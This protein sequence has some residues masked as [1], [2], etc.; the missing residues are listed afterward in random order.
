MANPAE[1]AAQVRFALSQLPAQNAHH[2][3]EQ[4]CRHLTE[5]F[6]CSNVLPAT[7]PVSAGGDQGRDFETFR[8]YLRDELGPTGAF[9][10]LVSEGTI[11]FVCTI[12]AENVTGKLRRD[13]ET[14]CSSG[15]PVHEIR[16]FALA[17]V[18]VGARHAL[19]TETRETHNVRL[20]LHD[21]ESIADLLARAQGFWIAEHFLSL[22]AEIRPVASPDDGDL[23]DDYVERRRRWRE[24]RTLYPT[25][26]TFLD[27]KAGLRESMYREAARNDLPFWLGLTRELLANSGL[28]AQI[29]QRARYELVVATLRGTG[30]LRPV[31]EVVRVYLN[32]SLQESEPAHLDDAST[33]LIYAKAATRQRITTIR[34]AELEYWSVELTRHIEERIPEETPHRRASLL[35]SLGFL[36]LHPTLSDSQL[37]DAA[38]YD[39][40][41]ADI[42]T[43]APPWASLDSTLPQDFVCRDAPRTLSAWTELVENLDETPLFPLRTLAAL[44]QLLL[45]LWSTQPEWRR[46]LDLVDDE[47]GAREGRNAVAERARARATALMNDGRNIEALEELHRARV[48]WWSGDTVR[49]SILASLVIARLYQ[50]LRLNTAAKAHALAAATIA[51]SGDEDLTDLAPDGLL[52][53]ALSEFLSGAWYGAAELYGLG[54]L[55]QHQLGRSGIDLPEDELTDSAVVHLAHISLCARQVDSALQSA[56]QAILDRSGL[57]DLIDEVIDHV[58]DSDEWTWSSFGE[59][60]LTDPPFADL[61]HTRCIRFAALGT[62]WTLLAANDNDS[63]RVAERFAAGVQTVLAALAREDLCLIPTE[64]TVRIEEPQETDAGSLEPIQALPSNEGREWTVRLAPTGSLSGTSRQSINTELMAVLTTILREASLLPAD[65]FLAVMQ[66]AF[67]RGLG[68]K[69]SAA[70]QLEEFVATFSTDQGNAFPRRSVEVPW[71][72]LDGTFTTPEELRWQDGPG[73]TYSSDKA[74]QLLQTRYENLAQGLRITTAVLSC[75]EEFRPT[76]QALRANGWLD[77]HILTAIANIT[78]NYRFPLSSTPPS[79]EY[80]NE[81]V[82]SASSPESATAPPVPVSLLTPE[83]MQTARQT[84]MMS[85]LKHWG[86]ECHQLTPD[87]S[88][89]E[90]LLVTRYGYWNEDVPH[91]DSFPEAGDTSDLQILTS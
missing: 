46:L 50:K 36:G 40:G 64:I 67:E 13:I 47:I 5:Q 71:G 82:R 10:G 62:S 45:P 65:D 80:L 72:C 16:A 88:A 75:S 83:R 25:L 59:G 29:Q 60:E 32:E 54:L 70:V 9:L 73:P 8:T 41:S 56:L 78:M 77:W 86:L 68:H 12:Q 19:E 90:R 43:V 52:M 87:I 27:L 42:H 63:V 31:D 49:E 15:H 26:G 33:L 81:M 57:R 38:V 2:A 7:G 35:S 84:A 14:V 85:L 44:L 1:V 89:I 17:S 79:G 66:R 20:E 23:P 18:P 21:A 74:N 53:A 91:E 34:A 24:E 30:E 51:T 69:L 6:I 4:L 11:A 37:P 55:A 48:D 58:P 39:A 3:F 28:P 76:V 22:P 61:G